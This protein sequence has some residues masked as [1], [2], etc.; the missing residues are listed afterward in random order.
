LPAYKSA[1]KDL[2]PFPSTVTVPPLPSW[3]AAFENW[4]YEENADASENDILLNT[5]MNP[6]SMSNSIEQFSTYSIDP[7]SNGNTTQFGC[8]YMNAYKEFTDLTSMANK[9]IELA[10]DSDVFFEA[11]DY[12]L[13]N[14]LMGIPYSDGKLYNAGTELVNPFK[15]IN[16]E[17]L[18]PSFNIPPGGG[19]DN[20]S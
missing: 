8:E 11:S 15:P 20:G 7:N 6:T 18:C 19:S 13:T 12:N 4:V 5:Y 3:W 9:F 17:V 16:Y 1:E 10:S 2:S 14:T